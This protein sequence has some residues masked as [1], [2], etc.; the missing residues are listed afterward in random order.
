[1]PSQS[2][3]QRLF[4]TAGVLLGLGLGGFID[5]IVFHQLLQWHHLVSSVDFFAPDTLPGL[6][7]NTF[8]DGAFHVATFVMTI[9]GIAL[10]WRA[11]AQG[12]CG[13]A[14][15]L[16]G[17]LLLGWGVFN[18]V[19]GVVDHLVLGVHHVNETVPREQWLWWDIAFLIWG[20]VM[21]SAGWWFWR[22]GAFAA[23]NA[24]RYSPGPMSSR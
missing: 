8:A 9:A 18:V 21:I 16:C 7:A 3:E 19:E 4:T 20:A 17:L 5:G 23:R 1:M 12:A 10:L 13:S 2:I 14:R 22:S 11:C 15:Q 24:A 6:R